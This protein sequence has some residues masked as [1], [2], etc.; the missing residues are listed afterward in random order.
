LPDSSRPLHSP[1]DRATH[2][3]EICRF[4]VGRVVRASEEKVH[5]ESERVSG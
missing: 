1:G 5:L 3:V 2:A 4:L